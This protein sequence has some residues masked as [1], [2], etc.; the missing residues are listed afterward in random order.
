MHQTNPRFHSH[1]GKQDDRQPT[2][3][4]FAWTQHDDGKKDQNK[5]DNRTDAKQGDRW[6]DQVDDRRGAKH[7]QKKHEGKSKRRRTQTLAGKHQ[8]NKGH[9]KDE[10]NKCLG[11]KAGVEINVVGDPF[12]EERF[13][14]QVDRQKSQSGERADDGQHEKKDGDENAE[15]GK[16][17]EKNNAQNAKRQ[18]GD[19]AKKNQRQVF[20]ALAIGLAQVQHNADIVA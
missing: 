7:N 13:K 11:K 6:I 8:A 14:R 20:V 3:I 10:I 4:F 18:N 15:D 9:G 1:H 16:W 17:R 12:Q 19:R 5:T 2:N